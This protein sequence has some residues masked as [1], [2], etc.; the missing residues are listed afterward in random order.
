MGRGRLR[1]LGGRQGRF[2][3]FPDVVADDLWV[4][5][6]FGDEEVEIVDSAPVVVP[7]PRRSRDLVRVLARTYRGKREKTTAPDLRDRAPETVTSTLRDLG[8]AGAAPVPPP[9]SM[10]RPTPPSRAGAR[11]AMA[12]PHRGGAAFAGGRWERDDSSRAI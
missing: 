8:R 1:A 5:R 4:D 2:G 12:L 6:L 11:L 9:R 3:D 10:R 7:V